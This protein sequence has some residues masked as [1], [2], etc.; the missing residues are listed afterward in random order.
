MEKYVFEHYSHYGWHDP[1]QRTFF[2]EEANSRE[3]A[4]TYIRDR[5]QL[6]NIIY[7]G[8]NPKIIGTLV[9]KVYKNFYCFTDNPQPLIVKAETFEDATE[10]AK[11]NGYSKLDAVENTWP[12]NL[13]HTIKNFK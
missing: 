6:R 13:I 10:I 4:E 5:V 12:Y 2:I 9:E 1:F 7:L 3:E 11:Q 8:E